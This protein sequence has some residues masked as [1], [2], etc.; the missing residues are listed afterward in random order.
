[1]LKFIG[2]KILSLILIVFRFIIKLVDLVED[3]ITDVN[4]KVDVRVLGGIAGLYVIYKLALD[5]SILIA[6]NKA[7][8]LIGYG[9][10][11]SILISLVLAL[12]GI[13]KSSLEA[14]NDTNTS[15]GIVSSVL[16]KIDEVINNL[17]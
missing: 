16:D 15:N 17:K 13:S 7:F 6:D 1:M 5:A 12:F 2:K 4:K 10:L 3:T 9:V 11:I 8:D 14:S